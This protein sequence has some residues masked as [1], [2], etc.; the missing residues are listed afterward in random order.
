[1]ALAGAC[2]EGGSK[3]MRNTK[4]RGIRFL[5]LMALLFMACTHSEDSNSSKEALAKEGVP[6]RLSVEEFFKNP[7]LHSV[8]ISPDA[9]YLTYLRPYE[10]RRNI[11]LAPI[12]SPMDAKRITNLTDRDVRDYFWKHDRIIYA[13]DDGGDE[14]TYLMSVDPQTGKEIP[15]TKIKG[16]KTEMVDDLRGIDPKHI[17]IGLNQ[18]DKKIFDVYRLDVTTGKTTLILKNPGTYSGYLTDHKGK[19]R[20]ATATDGVKSAIYYR[21]TENKPFQKIIETNFK[22]SVSPLFFSFDNKNLYVSSNLG[23]DKSAFYLFDLKTKKETDLVFASQEVDVESLE[24]SRKRKVLTS[25]SYYTATRQ[26]HFF[27][28]VTKLAFED[29]K[30]KLPQYDVSFGTMDDQEQIVVI[31][32]YSDRSLGAYYIYDLSKKRLTKIGDVNSQIDET[33]MAE[34]KPIE[35]KSRDGLTIFGYLTLP[36][37]RDP[38]NLPVVVTPHGGPW[39]RDDWGY[40]PDVQFLA[41]R[42]YAVLQMNF[43]G[44]TGYGKDFW[45]K[46]FK[47]WGRAMQDDVTDGVNWLIKEGIADPKRVGIYGG[48]YGGY[49]TLAGLTFTPDLYACGVDFVGV[50]NLFTFMESIPP[51]WE[52]YRQTLYEM[53]GH[54][55]KDKDLLT[56]SSPVFHVDKIKVPLFIAQGAND[57]RVK[58]A[59]S[60]QMVAALKKRGVEVQYLVKDNE[61]HGFANEENR[62]ELFKRIDEFFGACLK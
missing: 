2:P 48:S 57:P 38:K 49:A 35:Y 34:M 23:R 20:V 44:S 27:D 13:R 51:Y 28:E 8:K 62:I 52:P 19:L 10:S 15:L 39:Y 50:S 30:G 55:V 31:R 42:G 7:D 45:Q 61:G 4:L 18:R 47:Q 5:G 12:A 56:A 22:D 40:A 58:K 54:P 3:S 33:Q 24:Y 6:A 14:N 29:V 37:G 43:R 32:T 16:V 21:A 25:A 26:R 11:F 36:K 46:S 17:L 1:M 41:N 9:K 60:D 53:V 59:E